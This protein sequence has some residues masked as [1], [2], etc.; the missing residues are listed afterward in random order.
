VLQG[1]GPDIVVVGAGIAGGALATRLARDGRSVYLLEK[2]AVHVDRIRGEWLAPRGVQEARQLGI[3]HDLLEAGGH[4]IS[5]SLRYGD[6]IAIEAA[7]A[8]PI[9]LTS[10]V[11]D[12]PGVMTLSHPRLCETLVSAARRFGATVF[13]GV[14]AVVVEPGEHPTVLFDFEGQRHTLRPRI[15]FGAD[16]RG[17]QVARQ[18][19]ARAQTEGI[20]H[21]VAGLLVD[22]V[23]SWPEDEQTATVHSGVYQLV[24]PQ[25]RG[26][27]RLYLCYACGERRRF[28]GQHATKNFLQAFRVPTLPH[29]EEIAGARVAGPCQGYPN[30]DTWVDDPIAP[31]VVLIGDAA[32]HNDPTIG[33]GLSIAFRDV[34]MVVAA[35]SGSTDWDGGTFA[36]FAAERRERMRR[37]RIAARLVS[38]VRCEFDE[39]ASR[40]RVEVAHRIARN[41]RVGLPLQVNLKGPFGVPDETFEDAAVKALLGEQWSLTNDGWCVQTNAISL[42]TSA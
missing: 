32:G 12:V 9:D 15:V 25:G 10:M 8:S 3:L 23:Q 33:Q 7:R 17:S 5:K 27:V 38:K 39:D 34:N 31:G 40:R 6:G 22:G 37:L 30:A 11:P 29:G 2:S 1:G 36:A 24:F 21:L 19:G 18:M 28:S 13:R 16:G 26:R 42:S 4:Y 41:P 20:H 35:L 14:S